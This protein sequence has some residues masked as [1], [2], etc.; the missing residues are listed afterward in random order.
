MGR[1]SRLGTYSRIV[2]RPSG[3]A[4]QLLKGPSSQVRGASWGGVGPHHGD[5]GQGP[6]QLLNTRIRDLRDSRRP[7]QPSQAPYHTTAKNTPSPV[8]VQHIFRYRVTAM[9][10]RTRQRISA[11]P[12]HAPASR[13]G[14]GLQRPTPSIA[15]ATAQGIM[16]RGFA[17]DVLTSRMGKKHRGEV[18]LILT[19]PPFPLNRKKKLNNEALQRV[20]QQFKLYITLYKP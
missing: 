12:Q 4:E 1:C 16:Y 14:V 7:G 13:D 11:E 15:Y 6:L 10:N 20:V 8:E 18:Q 3:A 5:V 2:F 17:E 9:A 19:S